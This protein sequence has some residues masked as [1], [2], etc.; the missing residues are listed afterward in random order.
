MAIDPYDFCPCG[1]GKKLKFCC[2]GIIDQMERVARL[3]ASDQLRPALQILEK[4]ARGYAD[5]PWVITTYAEILLG[6]GEPAEAKS[7]LERLLTIHPENA[8]AAARFAVA[9]LFADGFTASRPAIHRALQKCVNRYPNQAAAL[10]LA[11]ATFLE[12]EG[13]WMATRQHLSLTMRLV[14]PESREE[15]F[16]MLLRIDGDTNIPYPLRSV[17]QLSTVSENGDA[18]STA[19]KAA[20]L[21]TIGCWG[22]GG[23]AF[24]RLAEQAPHAGALWRNAG[25]CRA[26]DGDEAAAADALHRAAAALEDYDE[27]VECET[28]AQLLDFKTTTDCVPARRVTYP[29]RSASRML[30]LLNASDRIVAA[31]L[32]RQAAADAGVVGRFVVLDRPMP[33]QSQKPAFDQFPL[34]V[35][36]LTVYDAVPDAGDCAEIVLEGF[37]DLLTDSIL[38]YVED[39]AADARSGPPKVD[40]DGTAVPL[41]REHTRYLR[42]R[43]LVAESSAVRRSLIEAETHELIE[44]EW[45]SAPQAA[46]DG[47]S[48]RE[49]QGDPQFAVRL[50]ASAF[51]LDSLMQRLRRPFNVETLLRQLQLEPPRPI[52]LSDSVTISALSPMQL[53]R[54]PAAQMTDAQLIHAHRRAMLIG[55]TRFVK[56]VL[57]EVLSRPQ[58]AE[59]VDLGRLY[60]TL[61]ALAR[62]DGRVED[63]IALARQARERLGKGENSFERVLSWTIAE[64]MLRMENPDDP[65][66]ANLYRL[67]AEYYAPKIPSVA[68][69]IDG[70][71]Q[72]YAGRYAWLKSADL[73]VGTTAATEPGAIW[74]P[75]SS[76]PASAGG[77]LWLPGQE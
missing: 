55:H 48:P 16:M 12:D 28:L 6:L 63:G 56:D 35:A 45:M 64:F 10:A 50:A 29:I 42:Y 75:G 76:A 17:H 23:R 5:N 34:V 38:S 11:A 25:L 41:P 49:V 62:E 43:H 8:P 19:A 74:T 14:A 3:Q 32:D 67:L 52:E 22:P 47:K 36:M 59:Q 57:T 66:L 51:V 4:L 65:E 44:G 58:C 18:G 37:A 7:Q 30:G 15:V 60:Q 53:H 26:W 77:K 46:L 72:T 31:P 1:S 33:D 20:A 39:V 27:A 24:A 71:R 61:V 70:F 2:A 69:M 9:S 21:A 40:G 54:V 13:K 73:L 68:R